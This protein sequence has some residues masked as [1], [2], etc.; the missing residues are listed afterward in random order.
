MENFVDSNKLLIFEELDS[1]CIPLSEDAK[2]IAEF[3]LNPTDEFKCVDGV[4]YYPFQDEEIP[5]RLLSN[6][7]VID[8]D[9]NILESEE[10]MEHESSRSLRI[11]ASHAL[12]DATYMVVL[13]ASLRSLVKYIK[14]GEEYIVDYANNI[15]MKSKDYKK[16]FSYEVIEE[17]DQYNLSYCFELFDNIGEV[18]PISIILLFFSEIMENIRKNV[19][20]FAPERYMSGIHWRNRYLIALSDEMLFSTH[21]ERTSFGEIKDDDRIFDITL[22]PL[23][24]RYDLT[25]TDDDFFHYKD[26]RFRRISDYTKGKRLKEELESRN[27]YHKCMSGCI[28]MALILAEQ[29]PPEDIR[30]ALGIIPL[31]DCEGNIHAWA[32]FRTDG[33][34]IAVDYVGNLMMERDDYIR[35]REIKPLRTIS[36]QVV[37]ELGDFYYD[38]GL[39]MNVFP[40]LYFAEEMLSAIERSAILSKKLEDC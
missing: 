18:V 38:S 27:R 28:W 3:T 11:A 17:I 6:E 15:I 19:P 4:Y 25:K 8:Y 7:R 2:R 29:K 39:R 1:R 16:I 20:T 10:R 13:D 30:V 24:N 9:K 5:F 22:D 40:M 32:E 14:D 31:N 33:K 37:K 34:W 21:D 36:Y 23:A 35:L 26:Y 12:P